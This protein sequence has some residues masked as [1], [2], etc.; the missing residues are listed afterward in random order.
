LDDVLITAPSLVE[1][2]DLLDVIGDRSQL[3]STV[4]VTQLP[5]EDWHA[6]HCAPRQAWA[7]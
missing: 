2:K 7:T 1:A 3:R 5:V 6:A 4:V